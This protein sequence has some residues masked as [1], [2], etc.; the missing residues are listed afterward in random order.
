VFSSGDG[1]DWLFGN[2]GA[3][4]L[5][6]GA[7]N[8]IVFGGNG[9]DTITAASGNNLIFGE[10]GND[11]ITTGDGAD[12]ID[13]GAGND[14]VFA[15]AGKDR[16]EGGAGKDVL[17]GQAGDDIL[18]GG[19]DNDR[20]WGGD[21]KDVLDAGGGNNFLSGGK[22][23]D[24]YVISIAGSNT[25]V[26]SDRG[27]APLVGIYATAKDDE[28]RLTG[29]ASFEEAVHSIDL[30]ISDQDLVIVY[31]SDSP[32]PGQTGQ[33]TIQ[34]QFLNARFAIEKF[35]IGT[36]SPIS[37]FHFANL[38]GDNF[39]FS[40][41]DGPDVGA[42]DFVFGTDGDDVI[43]G[44]FGTNLLLGGTGADL[45]IFKDEEDN[46][47]GASIIL[48]FDLN[49]DTLDFTEIAGLTRAGLTIS[50]NSFGNAEI[51][52]I[53]ATIEL[54]VSVLIKAYFSPIPGPPGSAC[55]RG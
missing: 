14:R 17:K 18:I 31:E 47:S 45:F 40:V 54:R 15:G 55:L 33:I 44:G 37:N 12:R 48:D 39:T 20:L 9:R 3:D 52:S 5:D 49:E 28:I 42:N 2:R 30:Q 50:D 10:S 7:G 22:G 36:S 16:I 1:N 34:N 13:S 41:H 51:S 32:T 11:R 38:M 53:Y 19:D 6:A 29:Y 25:D 26:I 4:S 35:A 46:R 27:D 23:G 43:Y 24:S 8:D 21:D